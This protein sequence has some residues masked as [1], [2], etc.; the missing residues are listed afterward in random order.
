MPHLKLE[1]SKNIELT[2]YKDIFTSLQEVL[3]HHANV[4]SKNCKSRVYVASHFNVGDNETA[5]FVHLEIA[6]LEGRSV[7]KKSLIGKNT[8]LLL[9]NHFTNECGVQIT[10]EIRDMLSSQYFKKVQC[11]R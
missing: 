5:A 3:F 7:E 10:V 4:P 8:L 6:L 9:Q 11:A 2:C 1:V